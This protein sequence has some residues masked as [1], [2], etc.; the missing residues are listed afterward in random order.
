[1]VAVPVSADDIYRYQVPP[2]YLAGN[3]TLKSYPAV[4]VFEAAASAVGCGTIGENRLA[5][6]TSEISSLSFRIS[7]FTLRV[8][9]EG[10]SRIVEPY[11][12]GLALRLTTRLLSCLLLCCSLLYCVLCQSWRSIS[13]L[14]LCSLLT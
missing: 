3:A 10:D 11:I 9:N 7:G 1:M 12:E 13:W 4:V 14:C 8:K 2:E 6:R 5:I